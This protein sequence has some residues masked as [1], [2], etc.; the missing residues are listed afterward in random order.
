VSHT[1]LIHYMHDSRRLSARWSSPQADRFHPNRIASINPLEI[2]DKEHVRSSVLVTPFD[3]FPPKAA[4][5]AT[6]AQTILLVG[7]SS[8]PEVT[9]V[10]RQAYTLDAQEAAG[11]PV[12][13]GQQRE[14]TFTVRE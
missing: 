9:F 11:A 2:R 4:W 1:F 14:W 7:R 12:W 6:R 13:S 10:E 8:S 5:Y 3:M